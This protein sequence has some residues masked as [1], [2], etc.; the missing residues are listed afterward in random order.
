MQLP[1]FQVHADLEERHWWFLGRRDIFRALLTRVLPPFRERLI[2]DVGCGTGGNTAAFNR[3]YTCV[4]IDPSLDAV[5]FARQRFPGIEFRHGYAP[6]DCRDLLERADA[7]LFLDVLE[8][9][10]D[11]FSL[12]SQL[13]A[14]MKPGA[15][16]LMMAPG[17]PELWGPHDRG[18]EHERR[19]S[20]PRFRMLWEG[21]SVEECVCSALNAR[22]HPIAKLSRLF[23]RLRGR[24]LGPGQ[25]DLSL[26]SAPVNAL[27]RWIFGGEAR[28]IVRAWEK[29]GRPYRQGVSVL[30]L[31]KRRT[32]T[33]APRMRP[34]SLPLDPRPWMLEQ[35]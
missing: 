2:L 5:S 29:R 17:D 22:L 7:V 24:S 33:I 16:L 15:Y 28:R 23:S 13:L 20:L 25:T 35:W 14:A 30:A 9:V 31:L 19:Y 11:D 27:L 6:Q 1:Q 10:Q 32:G 12:V 26:P 4:G 3:L 21:L 8:H 18:F 34:A